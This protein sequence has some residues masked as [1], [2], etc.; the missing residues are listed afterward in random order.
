[1]SG[2]FERLTRKWPTSAPEPAA[3]RTT[4]AAKGYDALS[5]EQVMARM[6]DVSQRD[7]NRLA[8]HERDHQNRAEVL[9]RIAARCSSVGGTFV[10]RGAAPLVNRL[11]GY[12]LRE[13]RQRRE[14]CGDER[15]DE[16]AHV[17]HLPVPEYC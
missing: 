9:E 3:A 2:F 7:L 17:H 10:T 16:T 12:V 14:Q 15:D 11:A 13:R 1:M 4:P 5:T 8:A 6:G